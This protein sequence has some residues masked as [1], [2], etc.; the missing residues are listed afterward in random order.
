MDALEIVERLLLDTDRSVRAVLD[1]PARSYVGVR[2]VVNVVRCSTL[3]V[4]QWDRV[5]PL[6]MA[7]PL[8]DDFDKCRARVDRVLGLV[9]LVHRLPLP[10]PQCD[11]IT[12]VRY[13]GDAYVR[14]LGCGSSWSEAEYQHLVLVLVDEQ[15][16][17]EARRTARQ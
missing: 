11:A 10:C 6:A 7:G 9:E 5:T 13:D 2:A 8:V 3:I 4:A 17:R 12:L 15:R 14:C 1:L 16:N